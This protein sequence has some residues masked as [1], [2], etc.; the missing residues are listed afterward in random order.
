M[1]RTL[2]QIRNQIERL[3]NTILEH[4][5][6]ARV[7]ILSMED[8]DIDSVVKLNDQLIFIECK[9]QV[10]P[11][12]VK[13]IK[14]RFETIAP[15]ESHMVIANYIT[16][17]AKELLRANNIGYLD[18]A[19]NIAIRLSNYILKFEGKKSPSESKKYSYRAFTKTG[20]M[21]VFQILRDPEL[22]NAPQRDLA[23]RSGVSLGT[24]PKVLNE[25]VR[26]KYAVRLTERTYELMDK[27]RLLESW[28]NAFNLRL[29]PSLYVRTLTPRN[30]SAHEFLKET[31]GS[32]V[33]LNSIAVAVDMQVR[34]VN[35]C[36]VGMQK[37]GLITREEVSTLDDKGKASITKYI[38]LTEK[39]KTF[40]PDAE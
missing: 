39:A 4:D 3:K 23:E 14:T 38:R 33:T 34:S 20:T 36:L 37:K 24:I 18:Q 29:F 17:K 16:P 8:D 15:N 31:E 12:N 32:D 27:E 7:E 28:V 6:R 22:I 10:Q 11:Q 25:L 5:D 9:S 13:Q 21:V 19:G 40:N 35:G 30:R 1:N 26:D 2:Y